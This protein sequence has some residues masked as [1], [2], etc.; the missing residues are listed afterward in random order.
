MAD[1]TSMG[2]SAVNINGTTNSNNTS[3]FISS[4]DVTGIVG[5]NVLNQQPQPN[6]NNNNNNNSNINQNLNIKSDYGLTTL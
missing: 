4:S 6:L 5:H 3:S 1:V 2:G